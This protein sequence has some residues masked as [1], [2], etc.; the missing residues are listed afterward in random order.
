MS[1]VIYLNQNGLLAGMTRKEISLPEA[2]NMALHACQSP[3]HVLGNRKRLAD[4]IGCT[5][6]DFVMP[7]QTHSAHFYQV[8]KEDK[9]RG[10]LDSDTSVRDTDALYT[11]ESNLALA[12]FTADCVP[13]LFFSESSN[14]VGA[15]HSGWQGTVKEITLKL[16]RH[17]KESEDCN[18]A[19]V[20]VILGAALSQKRFEVDRD[21]YDKYAALGYAGDWIDYE[22]EKGKF[23]IDNQRVVQRQCELAGIPAENIVSDHMCTYEDPAGFSYRENK[24]SGRHMSFIMRKND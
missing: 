23:L 2:N 22:I 19:D 21:V 17:L 15:I 1:S 18:P 6:G 10:A 16:F 5:L 20:K 7:D 13:I 3:A 11:Y 9:G 12:C 14:L 4:S 24:N 8:K